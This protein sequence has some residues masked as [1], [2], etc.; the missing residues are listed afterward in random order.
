MKQLR[1]PV[2][3]PPEGLLPLAHTP[4]SLSLGFRLAS[5]RQEFFQTNMWKLC[6]FQKL[7]SKFSMVFRCAGSLKKRRDHLWRQESL[8][9]DE[10]WK[11][12]ASFGIISDFF[13]N[14]NNCFIWNIF[15][16]PK[17]GLASF[18]SCWRLSAAFSVKEVASLQ[19]RTGN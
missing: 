18:R 1:N 19:M 9:R 16:F 2:S 4:Q 10:S 5:S 15:Y 3:Q 8:V 12:S 17:Q 13:R 14:I 7:I 6:N 11:G